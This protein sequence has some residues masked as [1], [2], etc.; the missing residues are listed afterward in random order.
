[1]PRSPG[2]PRASASSTRAAIGG[3]SRSRRRMRV[4]A[5]DTATPRDD[6]CAV[7]C[8]S[9]GRSR[10][11]RRSASGRP[12]GPRDAA[13]ADDRGCRL[14]AR[15]AGTGAWPQLDRIAVG[16]GPGTFTG[17]RIGIA[18]ARALAAARG[19]PLVGVSTLESLALGA[20]SSAGRG[21]GRAGG[22]RRPSAR[23]VRGGLGSGTA[24]ASASDFWT[25]S[26]SPPAQLAE[27]LSAVGADALA[28]GD[29]AVEFR[30]VLEHSGAL[31]PEDE[32]GP[33][34]G[35]G[36]EPL[37]ARPG[38]S[39]RPRRVVPEYLRLPDAEIARRAQRHQ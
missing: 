24:I 13:A 8:A 27:R 36:D 12:A 2:W 23:G 30:S 29:G 3:S 33:P 6:G 7:R 4:L 35:R 39:G 21:D 10:G 32:L 20:A 11:A 5:F 15:A 14:V 17:L 34:Q 18:T 25:R 16:V 9:G 38:H 31:I 28:V 37:S 19:I 1:M 22:A 26:R